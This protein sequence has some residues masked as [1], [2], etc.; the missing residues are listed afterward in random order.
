MS[1]GL[2]DD[3]DLG[4]VRKFRDEL[5]DARERIVELKNRIALLE[6]A[7]KV[8]FIAIE[9]NGERSALESVAMNKLARALD[10]NL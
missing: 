1:D 7:C 6:S 4:E 10:G 3:Y 2:D 5:E 9:S 8:A